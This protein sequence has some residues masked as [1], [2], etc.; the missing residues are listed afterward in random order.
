MTPKGTLKWPPNPQNWDQRP[1]KSDAKN[2]HKNWHKQNSQKSDLGPKIVQ[3]S[4]PKWTDTAGVLVPSLAPSSEL[5]LGSPRTPQI[6]PKSQIN[7]ISALLFSWTSAFVAADVLSSKK[8]SQR[9][10]LQLFSPRPLPAESWEGWRWSHSIR[11]LLGGVV[12]GCG[13]DPP[14]ASSIT[15]L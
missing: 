4:S 15:V 5:P 10:S 12:W 7:M 8:N 1:P 14:Q 2:K 9:K 13:D 6:M 3:N 11:R